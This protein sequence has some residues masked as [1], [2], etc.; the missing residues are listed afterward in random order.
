[1]DKVFNCSFRA[2]KVKSNADKYGW[3]G[4]DIKPEF[5]KSTRSADVVL[6]R[7]KSTDAPFM[8]QPES[9][10]F[11]ISGVENDPSLAR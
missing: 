10:I 7:Y 6:V 5:R 3:G 4:L 1:M 8:V 9:T 2:K 11:V